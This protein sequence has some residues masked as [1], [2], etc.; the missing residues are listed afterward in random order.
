MT[1]VRP[2]VTPRGLLSGTTARDAIAANRAAAFGRVA[3]FTALD[4]TDSALSPRGQQT[5]LVSEAPAAA[6]AGN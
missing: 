6:P 2:Y 4:L 1:L 3:A 5:F